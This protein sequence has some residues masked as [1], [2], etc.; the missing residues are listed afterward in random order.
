MS[1]AVILTVLVSVQTVAIVLV[2]L[3]LR[4]ERR[5]QA[6]TRLSAVSWTLLD[7]FV[8]EWMRSWPD[9]AV[10]F[11]SGLEVERREFNQSVSA[12]LRYF[13]RE[14]L[15]IAFAVKQLI[16]AVESDR[17]LYLAKQK[18]GPEE[19]VLDQINVHYGPDTNPADL[20]AA[21]SRFRE[22]IE[23]LQELV[24]PG[25]QMRTLVSRF[26]GWRGELPPIANRSLGENRAPDS[27]A[28][29]SP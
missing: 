26:R 24:A 10:E 15:N 1:I 3:A 12:A 5:R 25:H 18:A 17:L 23:E 6:I 11:Q 21:V 19:R 29:E 8:N 22:G 7:R 28:P 16:D 13:S 14:D 9:P 2:W 4:G 20:M 27:I